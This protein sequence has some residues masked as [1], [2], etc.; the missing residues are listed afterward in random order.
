MTQL[1]ELESKVQELVMLLEAS[2]QL[3]SNLEM[4]EV[5]QSVLLQMV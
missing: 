5:L 1:K 4:G 3:N 2:K